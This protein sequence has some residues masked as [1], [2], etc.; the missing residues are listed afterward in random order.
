[1]DPQAQ[2]RAQGEVTE[3][4]GGFRLALAVTTAQGHTERTL[5]A[6][7][8]ESLA[9]AAAVVVA[10]A[11]D[12]LEAQARSSVARRSPR[13]VTAP[14]LARPAVKRGDRSASATPLD[15]EPPAG[16]SGRQPRATMLGVEAGVGTG[17]LP[18]PHA[19]VHVWGGLAWRRFEAHVTATHRFGQ[20]AE[21][22]GGGG[23]V[24]SLTTG[25]AEL[26]PVVRGGQWTL[27]LLAALEAGAMVAAGR[28]LM[29]PLT[30]V[31]P[32]L[33]VSLRPGVAWSPAPW[34]ALSANATLTGS[35]LQPQ[36]EI[37]G[38]P[39]IHRVSLLGARI[40]LAVEFRIPLDPPGR[41]RG[42]R[43]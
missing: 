31:S 23:A 42:P 8:C 17:L 13:V 43:G 29:N 19:T 6:P 30:P 20:P 33:G 21:Q 25:G 4:A 16:R 26:G 32:W 24:I 3:T 12:P 41:G 1:V 14:V 28:G 36:F 15:S 34:V 35:L 27:R 7:A 18:R 5:E 38:G 37:E 9:Q 11:V 40:G 10:V 39:L 2:G 22:A